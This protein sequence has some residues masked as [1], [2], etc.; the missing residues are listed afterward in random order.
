MNEPTIKGCPGFSL[1]RTGSPL[2]DRAVAL[3]SMFKF[4]GLGHLPHSVAMALENLPKT[5][6]DF[7]PC[8][9]YA[10]RVGFETSLRRAVPGRVLASLVSRGW[11]TMVSEYYGDQRWRVCAGYDPRSDLLLFAN[12]SSTSPLRWEC[13]TT[14]EFDAGDTSHNIILSLHVN[15]DAR[16]LRP[17][18]DWLPSANVRSPLWFA[19]DA[20]NSERSTRR[21]YEKKY[22][23]RQSA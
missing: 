22:P 7:Y 21:A 11:P 4:Y 17:R 12:P 15:F 10:R 5:I 6:Y 16:K 20:R 2:P 19:N 18:P 8:W 14:D 1:F 23:T 3:A 13:C 9:I